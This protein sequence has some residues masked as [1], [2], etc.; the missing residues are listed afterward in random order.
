MPENDVWEKLNKLIKPVKEDIVIQRE[1]PDIKINLTQNI[2]LRN[3]KTGEIIE[4]NHKRYELIDE[5]DD[6]TKE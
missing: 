6:A 1:Q 3:K 4:F 2:F 5:E